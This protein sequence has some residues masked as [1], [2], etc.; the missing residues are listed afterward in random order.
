MCVA[1]AAEFGLPTRIARL[2]RTFGAGTPY[3][4]S[5]M[6]V[7]NQFTRK[8]LAG[9]DIE[10][11][12][13]GSSMANCCYT[14]DAARGLFT[15]MLKGKDG[16]A[17]NIANPA[18]STTIRK[19]AEIVANEVCGGRIKVVV[20]V[21]E[22]IKKRGYAPDVGYTMNVDKLKNLGWSPKYGLVDM[23]RRMLADWQNK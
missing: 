7:A 4:E 3:D 17:Y 5:D 19:M 12:T 9:E 20:N 22:D 2:A 10:L 14:A 11:H 15:V 23:Y 13:A 8:A 16:E 21:P 6:R 18:A 1:Y